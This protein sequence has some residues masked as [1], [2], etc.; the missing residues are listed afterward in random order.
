MKIEF[1]NNISETSSQKKKF[2]LCD[3]QPPVK[4]PAYIDEKNGSDWIAIVLNDDGKSINFNAIDNCV[5]IKRADGKDSK[6]C[7]GVLSFETTVIFV[8]L[9][10]RISKG[11]SWIKDAEEQLR[12]TISNFE[13]QEEAENFEFKK[14]YIA[15]SE[16]PKFRSSQINRMDRFYKE[17]DYIL[18]IENRIQL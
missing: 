11:N 13:K 15:N 4:E 6:R 10:Q 18:R 17:T 5:E 3:K 16:F 7:D 14:A 1:F 9:K 2:G 12:E 8:E